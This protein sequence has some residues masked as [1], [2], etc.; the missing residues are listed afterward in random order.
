LLLDHSIIGR[1]VSSALALTARQVNTSL[2]DHAASAITDHLTVSATAKPIIAVLGLAFK[3]TPS[4]MDTRGSFG[5]NLAERLRV[6]WPQAII[7]TWEPGAN[8]DFPIESVLVGADVVILAN[9]HPLIKALDIAAA[10]KAMRSGGM[11]YDACG[12]FD[13]ARQI[14]PNGVRLRIFG[15]GPPLE[16]PTA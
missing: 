12:G 1:H 10:A 3:G 6:Q 7:R 5:C 15:R 13:R 16:D 9:E 4:M 8:G 11:I 2:L 14:P